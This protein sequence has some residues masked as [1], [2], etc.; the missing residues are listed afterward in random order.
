M[1]INEED[2]TQEDEFVADS[3]YTLRL[4]LQ[5]QPPKEPVTRI[6]RLFYDDL[7]LGDKVYYIHPA[8]RHSIRRGTIKSFV[9]IGNRRYIGY[10]YDIE[11]DNGVV[12]SCDNVFH[13]IDEAREHVISNLTRHLNSV[14]NKLAS[15]QHDVELT[16]RRLAT[17]KSYEK[18]VKITNK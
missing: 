12:V 4:G 14:Q 3:V 11:L 9:W 16:K 10:D 5:R 13:T 15:L 8:S 7:A 1:V 17:L 18:K 6:S 2:L